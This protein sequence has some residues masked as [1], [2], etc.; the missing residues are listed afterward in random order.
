[1]TEKVRSR[2]SPSMWRA[3]PLM[4]IGLMAL[5]QL[6]LVWTGYGFQW[7]KAAWRTRDM[8]AETR[9]VRFM[10]GTRAADYIDFLQANVPAGTSIVLPFGVGEFT[11]QSLLQFFLMPHPIPGCDCGSTKFEEVTRECVLC[12]RDVKE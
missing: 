4:L 10:L 12:L 1:M 5:T 9:G 2:P 7:L 6:Y 8:P 3:V 11:Q